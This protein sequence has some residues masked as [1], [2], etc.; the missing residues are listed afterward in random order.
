MYKQSTVVLLVA[1]SM[2]FNQNITAKLFR[3]LLFFTTVA[4]LLSHLVTGVG[5][6]SVQSSEETHWF[7][8]CSGKHYQPEMSEVAELLKAWKE[9]REEDKRHYERHLQEQQNRFEQLVQGLTERRLRRVEVGP[10]SR[11]LIKHT[12]SDDIEAFLTTSERAVEAHGVVRDKRPANL[13]PQ[14]TGKVLLPDA[15][16]TDAV[17]H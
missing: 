5:L 16:M 15:A 7:M 11:K 17:L 3:E 1:F 14:L 12:E 9:E 4:Q 2:M 13:T 6:S 10:E 8:L